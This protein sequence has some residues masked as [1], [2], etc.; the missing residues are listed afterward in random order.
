M[1]E[2]T[3]IIAVRH[4]RTAWNAEMRMQGQLDTALDARGR[5]QAQQLAQAL[6]HEA[7]DAIVASDL[8]RAMATAAPLAEARGQRVQREPG[9]R[10]RSFGVFEGFTYA[11]I[12]RQWPDEV[13]RWRSR[14]PT[15]APPRGERLSAFYE[16]C[17]DVASRLA[18][19][20]PGR[21]VVWVTHGGVLDCLYRAAARIALDAP[22]TWALDNASVNRLLH[23]D[24]GLMLVGWGDVGHLDTPGVDTREA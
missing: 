9:L 6:A 5:W 20:H 10:E 8:S 1:R 19:R 21:A 24:Q 4:G 12:E 15:F 13:L 17:L 2:A 22:R 11:D 23:G 18:A 16:R 14:D 3:R 7:V